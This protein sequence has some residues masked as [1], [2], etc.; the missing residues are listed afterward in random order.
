MNYISSDIIEGFQKYSG[1][2]KTKRLINVLKRINICTSEDDKESTISLLRESLDISCSLLGYITFESACNSHPWPSGTKQRV[3]ELQKWRRS[4]SITM[5]QPLSDKEVQISLPS[6][7]Y[8][9]EYFQECL[10]HGSQNELESYKK[11]LREEKPIE[12]KIKIQIAPDKYG[13][14]HVSYDKFG[15]DRYI[16]NGFQ[17]ILFIDNTRNSSPEFLSA[18]LEAKNGDQGWVAKNFIFETNQE[19]PDPNKPFKINEKDLQKKVTVLISEHDIESSDHNRVPRPDID[20]DTIFL[21][22]S[23]HSGKEIPIKVKPGWLNF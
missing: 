13:Q 18:R 14:I 1:P 15:I 20:K 12:P 21:Y 3:E 6:G 4:F 9:N 23:L 8:L 10:N 16:V 5:H 19:K 22:I 11:K 17:V 2:F 7:T